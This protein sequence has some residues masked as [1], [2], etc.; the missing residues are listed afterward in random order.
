MPQ[1]EPALAEPAMPV[2]PGQ[3]WWRRRPPVGHTRFARGVW[4]AGHVQL[5]IAL[6][7]LVVCAPLLAF[8]WASWSGGSAWGWL[9]LSMSGPFALSGLMLRAS[10]DWRL[11]WEPPLGGWHMRRILGL[12]ATVA[13]IAALS[14][15]LTIVAAYAIFFI[16]ASVSAFGRLNGA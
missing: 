13:G 11:Y 16:A 1:A 5:P 15:I 10:S 2:T 12:T 7:L 14:V 9:G 6:A 3:W 4:W 8:G